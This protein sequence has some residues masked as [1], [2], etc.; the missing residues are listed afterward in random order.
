[1]RRLI[2]WTLLLGGAV[3]TSGAGGQAAAPGSFSP[4]LIHAPGDGD[5]AQL[6]GAA[7]GGR[8]LT[9]QQTAPHLNGQEKYLRRSL[10]GVPTPVTGGQAESYGEPCEQAYGVSVKPANT[11]NQFQ[12]STAA[13]LK[14]WPRPVTALP[15]SNET[16]RQIVRAELIQ[17]GLPSPEV[18]LV[19]LTRVDLD[20]DGTQEVIIEAT[21]YAG[22]EGIYPP[23]IGQ[24]GDYSIMLLRHVVR[25]QVL[26]VTLGVDI[27]PRTPLKPDNNFETQPLASVIRLAGAADLNG[28]GRMELILYSAY[29]E[30]T[31]YS[32][33][34]WTPAR[35]LINTPLETGCGV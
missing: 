33:Q 31:Y 24:P 34:E 9:T 26:T 11:S 13:A 5:R 29:Y 12:L 21:R 19:G 15:T 32:V 20:G 30:G 3:L 8:W 28:D 22:R 2:L 6:L 23:G 27:A 35:G 7:A 25:G 16:Y 17:R 14:A 10:G 4:V 1:M 18:Q